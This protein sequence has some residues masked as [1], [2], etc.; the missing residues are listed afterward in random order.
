MDDWSVCRGNSGAGNGGKVRDVADSG[1]LV[2]E[3]RGNAAGE[4]KTGDFLA[5]Y[6]PETA[7]CAVMRCEK[8]KL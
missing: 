4:E 1:N 2:S 7:T 3:G 6:V 5:T 8:K